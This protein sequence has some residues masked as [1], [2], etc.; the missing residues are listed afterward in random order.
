MDG[1]DT[2]TSLPDGVAF[3]A[4]S[5][6]A[7]GGGLSITL[8]TRT[9]WL[10]ALVG[11]LIL[12]GLFFLT[13]ALGPIVLFVFALILGEGMRPLVRRLERYHVPT[14]LAVLLIYLAAFVIL[15]FLGWLL[16]EPL[17]KDLNALSQHIPTYVTQVNAWMRQLE[18]AIHSNGTLSQVVDNFA[19]TAA[20]LL[21][22]SIPA[23]VAVPFGFLKGGIGLIF[24]LAMM[25]TM[26]VFW[27]VASKRL[28]PFVVGLFPTATQEHTSHTIG[29][30]SKAFGGYVRDVLIA[31]VLIGLM[32]GVGLFLL[33][34]P[35]TVL[36]AIFAGLM[37]VI[38]FIGPFISGAVAVLVAL[39]AAGPLKALGVVVLFIIIQEVEGEVIQPLVMSHAV[40][41]DP[42]LVI[43]A[44]LIGINVLGLAGGIL[45]V[46]V[47]GAIQVLVEEVVTP[48]IRRASGQQELPAAEAVAAPVAALPLAPPPPLATPV[49]TPAGQDGPSHG[50]PQGGL[51]TPG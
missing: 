37:E 13:H 23:L 16:L 10:I 9:I 21:Q 29:R 47:V 45:A 3:S 20:A 19:R 5:A 36:L 39:V 11:L 40:R 50:R 6:P 35:Y 26:T 2:C 4:I 51:A 41:I 17:V 14:A 38:P 43:I 22:Q 46:P 33:G 25:L 15:G 48:A 27:M 49:D 28:N 18:Q 30:L 34:V 44:C 31:M 24:N 32:S 12:V 7:R 8:S 42:L 1:M